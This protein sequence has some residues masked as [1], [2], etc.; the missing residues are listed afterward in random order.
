MS[1]MIEA[2]DS[3]KYTIK[4]Y[5]DNPEKYFEKYKDRFTSDKFKNDILLELESMI[6]YE[7][8]EDSYKYNLIKNIIDSDNVD[9]K[10]IDA[11]IMRNRFAEINLN[12]IKYERIS[13]I[14][15]TEFPFGFD[16][17]LWSMVGN[18][19]IYYDKLRTLLQER[20]E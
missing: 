2:L 4:S 17:I 20:K 10:Y 9:E 5:F 6:N 3:I 8:E 15:K 11:S 16:E 1:E 14:I 7:L 18:D 13:Q 12:S 19:P